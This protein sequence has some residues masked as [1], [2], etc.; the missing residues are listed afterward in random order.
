[1]SFLGSAPTYFSGVPI[2]VRFHYAHLFGDT[3]VSSK[4]HAVTL[5]EQYPRG[6]F[7]RSLQ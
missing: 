7:H 3:W 5:S 1:M 6:T 2:F 4:A